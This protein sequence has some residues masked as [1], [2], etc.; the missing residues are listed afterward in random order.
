[1]KTERHKAS[2]Y[3]ALMATRTASG[4]SLSSIAEAAIEKATKSPDVK[5]SGVN[6]LLLTL[7]VPPS[8]NNAYINN[9]NGHGRKL[10]PEA[11]KYK[12]AAEKEIAKAA[13]VQGFE[14]PADARLALTLTLYF[15][16]NRRRDISNCAKLPEDSLAT[17]LGFDDCR[18]DSL[19]IERAVAD[20][21][22]A[23]CEIELAII[24]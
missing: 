1:M 23:R 18:V 17:A 22:G 24:E 9:P 7:P 16:D 15:K 3:Q 14:C 4:R 12:E 13:I 5:R 19:F 11:R 2:D 8:V 20:K 6:R 21:H 10:S